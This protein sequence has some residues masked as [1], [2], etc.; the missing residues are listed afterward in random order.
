MLFALILIFFYVTFRFK[1]KF[2]VGA[3]GAL[4]HDVLILVGFFSLTQINFYL[5]ILAAVLATI[6]Y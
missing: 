6:G 2:A 4:I 3:L 1:W 5:T